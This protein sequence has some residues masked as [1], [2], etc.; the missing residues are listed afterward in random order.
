MKL[1]ELSPLP[2][3][4]V[5]FKRSSFKSVPKSQGCY[6]LTTFEDDILY[7]GLAT[8]LNQRFQQHLDNPEKVN[9]TKEGKATWFYYLSFNPKNLPMLERS[10]LNQFVNSHGKRP[11]LNKADSPIS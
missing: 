10:W 2:K 8:N 5:V 11:I 1:N 7:I 9:P 6:V 3:D 4:R